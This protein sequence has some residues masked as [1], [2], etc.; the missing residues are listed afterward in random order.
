MALEWEGKKKTELQCNS[1]SRLEILDSK[2]GKWENIT[3]QRW[4][5]KLIIF[6]LYCEEGNRK[7]ELRLQW[8]KGK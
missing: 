8:G 5:Q 7:Y 1:E 3:A 6:Y 2:H 4:E